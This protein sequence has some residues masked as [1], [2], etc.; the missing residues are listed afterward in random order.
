MSRVAAAP[1][2]SGFQ[3][4]GAAST[5]GDS[6]SRVFP[7]VRIEFSEDGSSGS[8]LAATGSVA[9]GGRWQQMFPGKTL[10]LLNSSSGGVFVTN[11]VLNKN[12]RGVSTFSETSGAEALPRLRVRLPHVRPLPVSAACLQATDS[13][14]DAGDHRESSSFQLVDFFRF[15]SW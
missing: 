14:T 6:V 4:C 2:V 3:C 5:D 15:I 1:G 10:G 13:F 7:S 12:R 9:P 8:G 11:I